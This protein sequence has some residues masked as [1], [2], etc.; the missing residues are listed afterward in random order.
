MDVVIKKVISFLTLNGW[1]EV[2]EDVTMN[3]EYL[4]FTKENNI[5]I[6][7]NDGEIVLI[8]ESGD[9]MHIVI[10]SYAYYTLLGALISK[11]CIAM[12]FKEGK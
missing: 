10:T 6:D 7:V 5:A 9:F 8:D 2:K 11:R 3:S 4:S 12:D 1:S